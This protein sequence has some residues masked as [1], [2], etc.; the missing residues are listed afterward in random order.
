MYCVLSISRGNFSPNDSEKTSH[1]LPL[2]ASYEVSFVSSW[3]EQNF[4][5]LPFLLCSISYYIRQSMVWWLWGMSPWQCS[6]V[7]KYPIMRHFVIEMCAH[8]HISATHWCIVGYGNGALWDL[9]NR[10]E[11]NT[12]PLILRR[13]NSIQCIKWFFLFWPYFFSH[14]MIM[15]IPL[16]SVTTIKEDSR[17]PRVRL[18]RG[19]SGALLPA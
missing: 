6:A 12:T 11:L 9:C 4:S 2:R 18:H 8:V 17:I 19:P 10:S 13:C 15:T 5:F 14:L 1:S 7:G 3:S 16:F